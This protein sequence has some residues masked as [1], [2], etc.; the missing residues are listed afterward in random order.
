MVENAKRITATAR[1]NGNQL[2]VFSNAAEVTATPDRLVSAYVPDITMTKAVVVHT[3]T[4]S[5][6]G[7][8]RATMP[9]LAACF[10]FTAECAMGAEPIPASFEKAALLIP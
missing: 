6:N 5:M 4:V 8:R 3:K 2:M 9:S 10:V 7:S 1:I